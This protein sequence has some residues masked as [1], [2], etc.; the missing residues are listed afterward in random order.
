MAIDA[1]IRV[2]FQSDTP[3]N[4]DVNEAL[5]GHKQE[6]TGPNPFRRVNTAV[7]SCT[8]GDDDSVKN[9]LTGFVKAIGRHTYSLDFLSVSLTKHRSPVD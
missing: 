1:I 7:Y 6:A 4:Q 5:V 3:A 9:A 2:S 8:N